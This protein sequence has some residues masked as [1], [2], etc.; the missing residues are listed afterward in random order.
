MAVRTASGERLGMLVPWGNTSLGWELGVGWRPVMESGTA[1]FPRN[2]RIIFVAT[3]D[4]AT[5]LGQL[6]DL[7]PSQLCPY[8]PLMACI[9]AL[10]LFQIFPVHPSLLFSHL[11]VP[12]WLSSL[13]SDYSHSPRILHYI[14]WFPKTCTLCSTRFLSHSRAAVLSSLQ[15]VNR[16]Q[17]VACGL[18]LSKTHQLKLLSKWGFRKPL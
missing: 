11:N 5:V 6:V 12:G 2:I 9:K 16:C 10:S 8:N 18:S 13:T 14:F 1:S 7:F 17:T 4:F 3:G 15:S